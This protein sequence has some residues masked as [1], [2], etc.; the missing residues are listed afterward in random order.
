MKNSRSFTGFD[1]HEAVCLPDDGQE[2][3]WVQEVTGEVWISLKQNIIDTAV[4]E[5]VKGKGKG[6]GRPFV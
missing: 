1:C 4:N 2:C 5:W 3:L 6:K